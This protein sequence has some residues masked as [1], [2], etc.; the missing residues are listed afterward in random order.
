MPTKPSTWLITPS[1]PKIARHS[2][3]T[4]TLLPSS[5]GR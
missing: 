3:T 2:I 5:D 4:A 1:R